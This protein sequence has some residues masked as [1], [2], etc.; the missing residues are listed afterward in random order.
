LGDTY[1]YSSLATGMPAAKLV[2]T[3]V[4]AGLERKVEEKVEENVIVESD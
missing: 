2:Q 1:S 3:L 4:F